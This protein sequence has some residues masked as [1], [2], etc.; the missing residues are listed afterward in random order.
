MRLVNLIAGRAIVPEFLQ[1]DVT[2]ERMADEVTDILASQSRMD[3]M[4]RDMLEVA[5]ML[6]DPGA[7]Q[8]AAHL[9][10]EMI[11]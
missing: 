8:R 3:A 6:G 2:P 9:A 7:S 4:K 11:E 5:T 10:Y 1:G